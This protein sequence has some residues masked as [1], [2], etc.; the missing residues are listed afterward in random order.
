ME[1]KIPNWEIIKHLP[2]PSIPLI[3]NQVK[4]KLEALTEKINLDFFVTA[5]MIASTVELLGKLIDRIKRQEL[6][7]ESKEHQEFV[8]MLLCQQ[9]FL[10]SIRSSKLELGSF[11]NMRIDYFRREIEK[12]E[13]KYNE[14]NLKIIKLDIDKLNKSLNLK[15]DLIKESNEK[16][17]TILITL[18]ANMDR[19]EEFKRDESTVKLEYELQEIKRIILITQ[20][21]DVHGY[22]STIINNVVRPSSTLS[23]YTNLQHSREVV[24]YLDAKQKIKLIF[25]VFVVLAVS[26]VYPITMIAIGNQSLEKC[27][28]NHLIPVWCLVSG[29]SFLLSEILTAVLFVYFTM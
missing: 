14:I 23:D 28:I 12:E 6:N 17:I 13:N 27:S 7:S 22:T 21:H 19:E 15:V 4:I 20:Q 2:K 18:T 3:Y 26:M 16:L 5:K 10:N 24:T 1:Q 25:V 8:D 29:S 9:N 11:L